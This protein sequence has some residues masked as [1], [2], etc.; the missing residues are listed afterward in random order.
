MLN[1]TDDLDY[2]ELIIE[3]TKTKIQLKLICSETKHVISESNI[4]KNKF[5]YSWYSVDE[6]TFN[7]SKWNITLKHYPE[8]RYYTICYNR[9][10]L[11]GSNDEIIFNVMNIIENQEEESTKYF[12]L[13]RMILGT[14]FKSAM[15]IEK[16]IIKFQLKRK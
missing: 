1:I 7:D 9:S 14:Q 16:R 4:V 2:H 12:Q 13:L 10:G 5:P 11:N 3:Q 15:E 6:I 8:S